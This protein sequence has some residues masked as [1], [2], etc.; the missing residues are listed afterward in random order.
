MQSGSERHVDVGRL[1][2]E[3]AAAA[4]ELLSAHCAADR[5]RLQYAAEDIATHAD[6][7]ALK[8]ALTS[9]EALYSFFSQIDA[10][11]RTKADSQR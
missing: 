6:P 9:A 11:L 3:L 2:A 4:V 5:V 10:Q 1:K 8:R 7:A